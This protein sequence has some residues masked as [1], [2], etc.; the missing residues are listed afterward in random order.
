MLS[1]I[2]MMRDGNSIEIVTTGREGVT[3]LS[4]VVVALGPPFE[5]MSSIGGPALQVSTAEFR[6]AV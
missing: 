4:G 3:G 5:V 6:D 1:A 2:A